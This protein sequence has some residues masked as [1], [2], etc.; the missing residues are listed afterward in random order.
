MENVKEQIKAFWH[1]K[2]DIPHVG[3]KPVTVFLFFKGKFD[4]IEITVRVDL[5]KL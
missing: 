2:W 1:R 3:F 5:I 4:F